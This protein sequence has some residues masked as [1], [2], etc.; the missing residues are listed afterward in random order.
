ML[1][2]QPAIGPGLR[3]QITRY[4]SQPLCPTYMGF[5]P[6]IQLVGIEDALEAIVAAVRNP[7]PGAVNVAGPGTIG[8]S[9]MIRLA[10]R[11][12]LPIA[13]PLFG[14]V[15]S[16]GQRL[17]LDTQ[18]DDFQRLLRYGRGVDTRRLTDEVG[19]TPQQSTV[20]AVDAWAASTRTAAAA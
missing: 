1:R 17:G 8:L 2:Y 20:Q 11:R 5:D 13:A 4:L 16:A 15:T 19:Y 3:T 10:G 12:A 6:R 9:R 14:A 7:V 18:S